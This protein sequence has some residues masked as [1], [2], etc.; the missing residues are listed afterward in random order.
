MHKKLKVRIFTVLDNRPQ[1]PCFFGF[2]YNVAL[3]IIQEACYKSIADGFAPLF[4]SR[5][6]LSGAS[7][8]YLYTMR[9]SCDMNTSIVQPFV[10]GSQYTVPFVVSDFFHIAAVGTWD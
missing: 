7:L 8:W 2:K 4:L 3:G 1:F 9:I 6:L 5:V 10:H